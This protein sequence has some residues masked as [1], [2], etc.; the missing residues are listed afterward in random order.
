MAAARMNRLRLQREMAARGWNACDLAAA[1]GL[2][3]ATLS[4]ALQ[5]RPVSLRTVQKIAVVIART[6]ATPQ[7]VELIQD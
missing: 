5:G 3:A 4:A 7:A 1:A 6:P 2:S